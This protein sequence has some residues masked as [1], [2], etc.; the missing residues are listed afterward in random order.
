[1][2]LSLI[3]SGCLALGAIPTRALAEV[4][5]ETNAV[6]EMQAQDETLTLEE[7]VVVAET[8]ATAGADDAEA[9]VEE[10]TP[11]EIGLDAQ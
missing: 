9:A 2:A 5:D 6:F 11:T 3:L 10:E 1:M 4:L 7:D 8:D